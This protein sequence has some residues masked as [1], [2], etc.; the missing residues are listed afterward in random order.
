MIYDFPQAKLSYLF[1][2]P[3]NFFDFISKSPYRFLTENGRSA[4][5]QGLKLLSRNGDKRCEIV[6]PAYNCGTEV[7]AIVSCGY[8]PIFYHIGLSCQPDIKDIE[9]GIN[10]RTLAV[11]V[12]HFNGF[13]QPI[14]EIKNLCVKNNVYLI[15]DCAHVL[16]TEISYGCLG[17]FGDAA[18]FSLGKFLPIRKGGL[19]IINQDEF[20]GENG[21]ELREKS[22]IADDLFFLLK[23]LIKNSLLFGYQP[24]EHKPESMSPCSQ[25][26]A[27]EIFAFKENHYDHGMSLLSRFLLERFDLKEIVMTRRRNYA[28]L[29]E[30]LNGAKGLRSLFGELPYG[31]CPWFYLAEVP[32]P[33]KLKEYLGSKSIGSI[34]FWSYF[35]K[36]FPFER[37]PESTYL[38]NHVI[39]LPIHQ[40]LSLPDLNYISQKVKEF[41]EHD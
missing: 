5:F 14:E 1:G 3:G 34:V 22:E 36:D 37:Y 31:V 9:K 27:V 17:T 40:D 8:K 33:W 30:R 10:Q 38:K 2:K 29:D 39:A 25:G 4:L 41:F 35:H 26:G 16:K 12:T 15:E 11:L 13:P 28:Y 32:D 6:V 24:K 19:L 21:I 18:I 20:V 23:K 7:E